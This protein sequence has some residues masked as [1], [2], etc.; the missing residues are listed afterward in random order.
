MLSVPI[1]GVQSTVKTAISATISVALE[2]DVTNF[3]VQMETYP[4][5]V[6]AAYAG[7]EEN[8]LETENFHVVFGVPFLPD[9]K[10]S[11]GQNFKKNIFLDNDTG[12]DSSGILSLGTSTVVQI[13]K[14]RLMSPES[15]NFDIYDA[16]NFNFFGDFWASITFNSNKT[17]GGLA[18]MPGTSPQK[19]AYFGIPNIGSV[20]FTGVVALHS[21]TT[22]SNF[23]AALPTEIINIT[24]MS[25]VDTTGTF[26]GDLFTHYNPAYNSFALCTTGKALVFWIGKTAA[27]LPTTAFDPSTYSLLLCNPS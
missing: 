27:D 14:L 6:L 11:S 24:A 25:T 23:S 10:L 26:H 1:A 21:F 20:S 13:A 4:S 12:N 8:P 18:I 17:V 22:P 2:S 19:T 9:F 15:W 5:S 7:Q 3:D 16:E